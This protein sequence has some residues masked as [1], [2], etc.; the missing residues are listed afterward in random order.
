MLV[1]CHIAQCNI[2]ALGLWQFRYQ[3]WQN[4]FANSTGMP[5]QSPVECFA[6]EPHYCCAFH[7][8]RVC[9]VGR[10]HT[11]GRTDPSLARCY[12]LYF[13]V[14]LQRWMWLKLLTDVNFTRVLIQGDLFVLHVSEIRLHAPFCWWPPS[15][16]TK[17]AGLTVWRT[18]W[19]LH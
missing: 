4:T 15:R 8:D 16:W 3:T 17:K 5:D 14:A 10:W 13:A 2:S 9:C 7:A 11:K 6:Q 1:K 12:S 19:E 18:H